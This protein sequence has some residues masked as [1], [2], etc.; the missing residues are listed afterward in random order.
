MPVLA[1]VACSVPDS[2]SLVHFC[3]AVEDEHSGFGLLVIVAKVV[4]LVV[5]SEQLL[6]SVAGFYWLDSVNV[7]NL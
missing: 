2:T 5:G 1:V 3:F 4:W 7:G 6:V